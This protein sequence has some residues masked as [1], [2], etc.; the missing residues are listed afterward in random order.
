MIGFPDETGDQ[1]GRT[2]ELAQSLDVDDF[3]I[4]LVTPL[5][6]TPLYD[7]CV[8]RGLLIDGFDIN[9]IRFSTASIRLPETS[10]QELE[11]IRRTVWREAFPDMRQRLAE[12][13]TEERQR[14]FTGLREYELVGFSS[15]DEIRRV[16]EA[17]R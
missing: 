9:N 3:Y 10:P 15:L 8:E 16:A 1:I 11:D 6:G 2:I 5:P 17:A 13:Q 12:T 4:S 7:E 14:R